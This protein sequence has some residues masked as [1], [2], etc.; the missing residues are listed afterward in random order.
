MPSSLS[1]SPKLLKGALV[2]LGE[3]MLGPIPDIIVFQYN[4][5]KLSR[6]FISPPSGSGGGRETGAATTTEPFDPVESFSLTLELDAADALEFPESHPVAA[7]SGVADRI[8]ALEMLVYPKS[9]SVLGQVLSPLGLGGAPVPRNTVPVALFV[10]GP[11]RILPVRITSLSVEEESYSPTLFPI[12]AKV[13]VGLTV[14]KL[15][16]FPSNSSQRTLS[17]DIAVFSYKYTKGLKEALAI[18]N[19][20]NSAESIL[21]MLPF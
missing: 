5:E 16:S 11:G 17:E 13:T 14:L 7:V 4:P 10:W 20:A 8:A 2:K 1:S 6:S 3:G 9:D 15:E 18:A 19:L 12:R 21:A